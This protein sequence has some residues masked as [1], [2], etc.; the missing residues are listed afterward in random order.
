[1][2]F[3]V[4]TTQGLVADHLP[5]A[6]NPEWSSFKAIV[7]LTRTPLL[8]AARGNLKDAHLANII[9]QASQDPTT[10]GIGEAG[11]NLERMLLMSLED[12]SGAWFWIM[13]Y[14]TGR[15]SF[16]ALFSGQL[17]LGIISASG[18]KRRVDQK[19]F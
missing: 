4:A 15:Q 10:V 9:E 13:T 12:A 8:V 7:L 6:E 19:E 3:A 18:A 17:D 2:T 5:N 14:D 16:S 1:V 11:S